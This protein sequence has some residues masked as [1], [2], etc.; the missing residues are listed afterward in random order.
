MEIA[1]IGFK[2]FETGDEARAIIRVI[3]EN[4]GLA[5]SLKKNGDMEVFFGADALNKIIEALQQ[6]R[7]IVGKSR[8]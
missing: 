7:M 4:T 2:D 3:G 5:L 6:A 1:T 8:E